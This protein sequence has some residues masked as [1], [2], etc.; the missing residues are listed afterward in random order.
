MV[1]QLPFCFRPKRTGASLANSRQLASCA[2]C[3]KNVRKTLLRLREEKDRKPHWDRQAPF[4]AAF[5]VSRGLERVELEDVVIGGC[6]EVQR[7]R[8]RRS[9][10]V[11]RA[12]QSQRALKVQQLAH[13]VE[14]WRDVRFFHLDNI[15]GVIHGQVELLHQVGHSHRDGAADTGKAVHEDTAL[16]TSSLIYTGKEG[17]K[18]PKDV[19]LG[20]GANR[21]RHEFCYETCSYT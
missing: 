4:A 9:S 15:V 13:E 2:S 17:K 6:A 19:W 5:V 10:V 20:F 14:I 7:L 8:R 1:Q 18:N 3:V 16:L 11:A 21:R 12:L